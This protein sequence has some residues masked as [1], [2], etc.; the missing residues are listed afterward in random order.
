MPEQEA[1]NN[2]VGNYNTVRTEGENKIRLEKRK[3]RKVMFVKTI[4]R[5]QMI[6]GLQR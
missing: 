4:G 2:V 3:K 1:L 6:Q 5:V